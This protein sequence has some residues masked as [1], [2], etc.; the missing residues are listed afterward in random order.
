MFEDRRYVI[1][2]V[3]ELPLVD[4]SKVYETSAEKVRKS[5]DQTKTFV[6]WD[7]ETPSFV[8]MLT[9]KEGIYTH[10]E[11]LEIVRGPFWTS[12]VAP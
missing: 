6:K 5:L 2:N 1:F 8:D 4:F 10:Q 9:T 11:M 3:S 12:N 7:G